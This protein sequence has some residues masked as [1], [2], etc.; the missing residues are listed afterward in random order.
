MLH[1][2]LLDLAPDLFAELSSA[3]LITL[4]AALVRR[5]RARRAKRRESQQSAGL[6]H[7]GGTSAA[8]DPA[9]PG[10]S[11]SPQR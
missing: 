6:S 1:D 4:T 9:A 10:L 5:S 7:T 3:A 8:P 2:L 11:T